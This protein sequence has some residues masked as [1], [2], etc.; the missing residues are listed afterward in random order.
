[1]KSLFYGFGLALCLAPAALSQTPAFSSNCA[2]NYRGRLAD[3]PFTIKN[4]DQIVRLEA[5]CFASFGSQILAQSAT[6]NKR[7]GDLLAKALESLRTDKQTSAPATGTG[8][9]IVS[10]G[11]TAKTIGFAA[12]AGALTETAKGQTVTVSG[13]LAGFPSALVQKNLLTFCDD[14][15]HIGSNCSV[16]N[17]VL[18]TLRKISYSVSFDTSQSSQTVTGAASGTG[19]AGGSTGSPSQPQQVTF[20]ANRHDI[21][22]VSARYEIWTKRDVTSSGFARAVNTASAQLTQSAQVAAAATVTLAVNSLDMDKAGPYR[23]WLNENAAVIAATPVANRLEVFR[24]KL[25]DLVSRLEMTKTFDDE[26]I[27]SAQAIAS[28]DL[29]ED[30][31]IDSVATKPVVSFE[32]VNNRPVGQTSVSIFRGIGEFGW[33]KNDL[34]F[35]GAI[36]VYDSAQPVILGQSNSRLRDIEFGA[37]YERKLGSLPI[38]G[39][40]ALDLSFYYQNQRS[41]SILKVDPTQPLP[42]IT[43]T[44]LPTN[45]ADVFVKAGDTKLGQLRFVLGPGGSNVRVPFS[46]SYSNRTD[47]ITHPAWKAQVGISYDFDSLFH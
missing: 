25:A 36:G 37:Q 16:S 4:L 41:A 20:Q 11:V 29:I 10:R 17:N 45:A 47:L 14:R 24:N 2:D 33:G 23:D 27:A 6:S 43:F 34:T 28:Y 46:V 30:D 38:L 19:T 18:R 21:S 44:G 15:F 42:G 32:Y 22:S 12:E 39:T 1:M 26:V 3:Q 8:T 13:T 35:N 7:R 5:P 9:T 31:L 40:A